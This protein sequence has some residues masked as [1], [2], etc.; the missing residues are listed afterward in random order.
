MVGMFP[1]GGICENCGEGV[2][3]EEVNVEAFELSG[4]LMCPACAEALFEN[5][6][7]QT[8]MTT[9]EY[10]RQPWTDKDVI[11]SIRPE[12]WVAPDGPDSPAMYWPLTVHPYSAKSLRAI[13]DHL[14]FLSEENK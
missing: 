5:L 14:D 12:C 9:D 1:D 3:P 2:F 13:A 6:A 11:E 8:E 10:A 4:N 7:D